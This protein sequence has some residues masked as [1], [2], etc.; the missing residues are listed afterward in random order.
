MKEEVDEVTGLARKVIVEHHD[1]S[2]QPNVSIRDDEGKVI[3][4]YILPAGCSSRSQ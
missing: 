2:R 1:E 3:G 4:R